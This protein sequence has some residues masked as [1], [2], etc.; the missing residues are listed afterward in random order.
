MS[1]SSSAT[2]TYVTIPNCPEYC[3]VTL[4]EPIQANGPVLAGVFTIT[5]IIMTSNKWINATSFCKLYKTKKGNVKEFKI[6]KKTNGAEKVIAYVIGHYNIPFCEEYV[7][8]KTNNNIINGSYVHS[9]LII[10]IA[11]WCDPSHT[12]YIIKLISLLHQAQSIT[13]APSLLLPISQQVNT[14][15]EAV[16]LV[17]NNTIDVTTNPQDQNMILIINTHGVNIIDGIQVPIAHD[18]RV[19]R[20]QESSRTATLEAMTKRHPGYDVELRL[21]T[22]YAVRAWKIAK[23]HMVDVFEIKMHKSGFI[24]LLD[25]DIAYLINTV[26]ELE[27]RRIG[28]INALVRRTAAMSLETDQRDAANAN[29][30][31]Q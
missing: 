9:D 14:L 11:N 23:R 24:E 25:I 16:N 21:E 19:C 22:S 18:Y 1:S 31:N 6:W 12:V 27:D 15:Q 10:N 30:S 7:P 28:N 13:I 4:T 17:A 2:L 20:I 29:I 3:K 8:I 26:R 5:V